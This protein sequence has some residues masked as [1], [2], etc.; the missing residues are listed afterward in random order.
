[1][2]DVSVILAILGWVGAAFSATLALPQ[3]IALQ[4]SPLTPRISV[5]PWQALLASNTAWIYYGLTTHDL[6]IAASSFVSAVISTGVVT[7]IA[8]RTRP[9]KLALHLVVPMIVAVFLVFASHQPVVFGVLTAIPST[10]GWVTQ[11]CRFHVEGRPAGFSLFGVI[12]YVT[13]QAVWLVFAILRTDVA[14]VASTTPLII[15]VTAAGILY[16]TAP[17]WRP[18]PTTRLLRGGKPRLGIARK[19]GRPHGVPHKLDP[20]NRSG[21]ASA[22]ELEGW[23]ATRL[24]SS[25]ASAAMNVMSFFLGRFACGTRR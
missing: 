23:H 7:M 5:K 17:P 21:P 9:Q 16:L 12:L 8:T 3:A 11:A 25:A 22:G 18:P 15:A 13:C 6:P 14:L 20:R 2:P 19:T 4:K 24:I 1:M 10:L